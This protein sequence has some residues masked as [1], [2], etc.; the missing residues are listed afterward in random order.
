MV[1]ITF[2]DRKKARVCV[3]P[4][5]PGIGLACLEAVSQDTA[6]A[7]GDAQTPA[8]KWKGKGW[9]GWRRAAEEALSNAPSK[10]LPW[11]TLVQEL[12]QRRQQQAGGNSKEATETAEIL[13][14]HA[15][16]SLPE[17]FLSDTD[18]LVRLPA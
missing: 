16:A 14:L 18:G 9:P 13:E 1:G 6:A 8:K 4:L 7:K 5:L 2:P 11:K 12:V 15:L 17:E 10:A 3:R